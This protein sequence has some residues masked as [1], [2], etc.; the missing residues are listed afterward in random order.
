MSS[1]QRGFSLSIAV[2]HRLPSAGHDFSKLSVV[3]DL[4]GASKLC[5]ITLVEGC[6][7][8]QSCIACL[9]L[10]N[11]VVYKSAVTCSYTDEK[12]H[13]HTHAVESGEGWGEGPPC[14]NFFPILLSSQ[15]FH[16]YTFGELSTP[17]AYAVW[18]VSYCL[19]FKVT[20]VRVYS[21]LLIERAAAAS[22][23][24]RADG[25]NKAGY[26]PPYTYRE[27]GYRQGH[28]LHG[29]VR[30]AAGGVPMYS[31]TAVVYVTHL[32]LDPGVH[33]SPSC[34]YSVL[35]FDHNNIRRALQQL[36]FFLF[37]SI[38]TAAACPSIH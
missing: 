14:A 30:V 28:K 16:H 11:G 12:T 35:F 17:P 3:V 22:K 31:S 6:G 13:K 37:S 33:A 29:R 38:P 8:F 15:P 18:E 2:T 7:L 34:F 19:H 32:P 9:Y 20:L 23:H 25:N 10:W 4:G 1:R 26:A 5:F 21:L 36:S 24:L 27:R